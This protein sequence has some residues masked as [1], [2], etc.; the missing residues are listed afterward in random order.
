MLNKKRSAAVAYTIMTLMAIIFLLP[1]LWVVIASFDINANPG[2]KIPEEWTTQNYV[3]VWG[4]SKN[5]TAFGVGLLLS[6][7]QTVLVVIVT[8]LASYPLS[9]YE[10]KYKKTFMYTILFMSCLPMT[11]V[12]IPVYRLFITLHLMDNIFGVMLFMTATALPYDMWMMKN[13]MDQVPIELEEAAWVDGANTLQS[14]IHVVMPLMLPGLCTI[15]IFAFSGSWGNFFTPYIL[16]QSTEK[17]P[18]SVRL[19][20]FFGS[21]GVN[22]GQLAA[23]SFLYSLPSIVL[24]IMSQSF[25]SKGFIMQGAN[26]G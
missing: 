24:Y 14:I 26:K 25:M 21:H 2:L 5:V 10:L 9:R 23:Y 13:F 16:L 12:M 3:A 20:Q 1:V 17:Y 11:T 8:A 15:A 22:Y 18:A 4:D 6:L 7:G 19:Y